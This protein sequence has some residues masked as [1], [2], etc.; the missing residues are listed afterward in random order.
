MALIIAVV[1]GAGFWAR[2]RDVR[3]GAPTSD[4]PAIAYTLSPA[5]G[6]ALYSVHGP[7]LA[8]SP[9]GRYIVYVGATVNR[10]TQLWLRSLYSQGEQALPGTD[11]ASTPFWS[12]DSQWIG[13]FAANSLKKVRI[14]SGLTQVIATNVQSKGGAAWN[15]DDVILF[16]AWPGGLSRVS[17]QG[18]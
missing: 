11:G 13:F 10:P 4:A 15:A 9:D 5:D 18:G 14:S 3:P 12:S 7:P 17:A 2:S 8:L 6:I 1:A 16:Q